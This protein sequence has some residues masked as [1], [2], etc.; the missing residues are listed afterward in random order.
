MFQ[1]KDPITARD[2]ALAGLKKGNDVCSSKNIIFW[3]KDQ[4][5]ITESSNY[6]KN[7]K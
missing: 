2:S 6:S 7:T 3:S 4:V 5:T 1:S